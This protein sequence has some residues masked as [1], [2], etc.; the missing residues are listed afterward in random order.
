MTTSFTNRKTFQ[1]DSK[2]L[3]SQASSWG[4]Q[5]S[6]CVFFTDNDIPYPYD[7]FDTILAAG[8][9]SILDINC[10]NAFERLR[11][12][13]VSNSWL[14]GYFGYDLKNHLEELSS[15]NHDNQEAPPYNFF[16]PDHLIHFGKNAVVIETNGHPESILNDILKS[17]LEYSNRFPDITLHCDFEKEEYIE[18]VRALQ[19][20]IERGDVY[21]INFC[22]HFHSQPTKLDP[23]SLFWH[24][25]KQSPAP[26][27][28]LL[29]FNQHY[30]ICAS[31]ERFL[32]KQDN[33]LISQPIKGTIRRGKNNK[34]DKELRQQLLHSDKDRT[35]NLMIVDLV[36]NDLARS[37]Q[38]GSIEV[39]ELFGIYSFQQVHQMIS[40]ITSTLPSKS[41]YVDAIENAFP[42]GSMTGAPKIRVMQLI[43]K[44]E[45]SK[46]GVYSG[47]AGFITP[48]GEFDFNVVIR[49]VIYNASTGILSFGVGSAITYDSIPESEYEE[50]LLKAKGIFSALQAYQ[51]QLSH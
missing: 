43:E 3:L 7:G 22:V 5:F 33:K 32:K 27:A 48:T 25:N 26:F 36:R 15:H 49:S 2:S 47:A 1:V 29:K 24:L 19:G 39:E 21:E 28:G 9:I 13:D 12:E 20:H 18:A 44:Y 31:P 23:L 17:G 42:M 46:R 51:G 4:Q 40:T 6:N 37:S 34:S 30:I 11:K 8:N 50:C 38:T 14:F 41:H 16:R 45:R 10:P 35:E